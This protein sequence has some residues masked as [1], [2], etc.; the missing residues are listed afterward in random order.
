MQDIPHIDN[1]KCQVDPSGETATGK[2]RRTNRSTKHKIYKQYRHTSC[3][4]IGTLPPG[5]RATKPPRAQ[6]PDASLKAPSTRLRLS[7]ARRDWSGAWSHADWTSPNHK[8]A[9]PMTAPDKIS[10]LWFLPTFAIDLR[11]VRRNATTRETFDTIVVATGPA[12]R[13]PSPTCASLPTAASSR[14]T[15]WAWASA[16]PVMAG[17]SASGPTRINAVHRR[18]ARAENLR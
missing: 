1:S 2:A 13:R 12:H 11:D 7:T 10:A 14:S 16:P 3:P 4:S 6:T 5:R 15:L 18:T 9:P 17:P 8:D